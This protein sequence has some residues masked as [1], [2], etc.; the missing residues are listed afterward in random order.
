MYVRQQIQKHQ[1]AQ[2]RLNN[3]MK[4]TKD[5]QKQLAALGIQIVRYRVYIISALLLAI[6]VHASLQISKVANPPENMDLYEEKRNELEQTRIRFDEN[7]QAQVQSR[8]IRGANVDPSR[9][10]DS[11]PFD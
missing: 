3:F 7:I 10:G 4:N 11:N 6:F 1:L 8:T 5:L 9:A 2:R